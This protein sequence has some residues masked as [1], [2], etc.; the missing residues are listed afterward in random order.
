MKREHSDTSKLEGVSD[1]ISFY[2]INEGKLRHIF[3]RANP[4][5]VIHTA[6]SYGRDDSS[7][8]NLISTNILL[9][10]RL[11]EAAKNSNVS[12]FINTD[13]LLPADTSPYAMSKKQFTD[14]L[15]LYK[16]HL[17][18]I[19]MKLEHLYGT[20]REGN[21]IESYLLT[22]LLNNSEIVNLTD[23]TQYRDFIHVDDAVKAYEAVMSKLA[24]FTSFV[25]IHVATGHSIQVSDFITRLYNEFK[26]YKPNSTTKL[27]FG[28]LAPRANEFSIKDIDISQL[29]NTGWTAE[30]NLATGIQKM[31]KELI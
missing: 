3:D 21:G 12:V 31:I 10:Q 8:S 22:S 23:G 4:D 19:N 1:K 25:E 13:T 7:F 24:N 30:F 15:Q 11:I 6:W 17:L 27:N 26:A 9:G 29:A 2:N 5:I 20:G 14:W 16:D 28:A 18:I